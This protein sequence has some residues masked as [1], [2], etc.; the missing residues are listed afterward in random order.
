MSTVDYL[1]VANNPGANVETQA[2]YL[3]EVTSGVL[4][5]G[6]QGGIV[7]S[8]RFNKTIRQTSMV[9]AAVANMISAE[10]AIDV[11]DDGNL[12]TLIA[13]LT[14]AISTIAIAAVGPAVPTGFMGPYIGGAAPAGWVLGVGTIGNG[15]SGASTRANA[16]TAALFALIWNNWADAQ[17]PVSSG[18]GGSAAIDYAANKTIAMPDM[19][20]RTVFGLDNMGGVAANRVTAGVSGI[21]GVVMGATGGDQNV[22][23][24]THVATSVVTDPGHA[25]TGGQ[26]ALPQQGATGGSSYLTALA[27]NNTGTSVTGV[28]VATANANYGTGAAANMPPAIMMPYI[29][30]L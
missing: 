10:L 21:N 1:A 8:V 22:Q 27:L 11:L 15:A 4:Q 29:A 16:D 14:S 2:T 28:T 30:K 3:A 6:Y 17:A 19:R 26:Q 20:G 18:R 9:A 24:H 7:P 13:N 12:A 5:N 25:H 23:T